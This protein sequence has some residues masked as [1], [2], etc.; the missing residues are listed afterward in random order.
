MK[1]VILISVALFACLTQGFGQSY[2]PEFV[3]EGYVICKEQEIPMEL[4]R[5]TI[6][7]EDS[8]GVLRFTVIGAWANTNTQYQSIEGLLSP[9]RVDMGSPIKIVI[10]MDNNNSH[11]SQKMSVVKLKKHL[12]EQRRVFPILSGNILSGVEIE[13]YKKVSFTGR[14]YGVASYVLDLG[15]LDP[16]EYAIVYGEDGNHVSC[17]A[18]GTPEQDTEEPIGNAVKSKKE[19]KQKVSK[20]DKQ[21]LETEVQNNS[22]ETKTDKKI[23]KSSRK[24]VSERTDTVSTSKKS[25]AKT[26]KTSKSV[27]N[28]DDE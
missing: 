14:K 23:N 17:F 20:K 13:G 19:K 21:V 2:E 12:K 26:S 22:D 28:D 4:G 1:K 15:V 8:M 16:G 11:P 24:R 6:L 10:R 3:G 5:L 25:K 27:K 9:S 18:V 7:D